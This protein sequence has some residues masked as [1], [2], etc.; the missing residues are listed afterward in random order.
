MDEEEMDVIDHEEEID[1]DSDVERLKRR[2]DEMRHRAQE[3]MDEVQRRIVQAPVRLF[4]SAVG[5]LPVQTREHLRLSVRESVLA[6]Q[7]FFDAVGSAGVL[8]VDRLFA[9]PRT[10]QETAQPRR[11]AIEREEMSSL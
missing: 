3:R 8:A 7:S 11:I 1:L 5:V 6:A 2:R 4:S 9:D 10:A